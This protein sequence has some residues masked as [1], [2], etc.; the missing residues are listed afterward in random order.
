MTAALRHAWDARVRQG[1]APRYFDRQLGCEVI[2]VLP[3]EY[4]VSAADVT[5]LTLLGSCVAACIR[6]PLAGVGGM[7][8]FMLPDDERGTGGTNARYGAYAMEVLINELLKRGGQR[9]RLEA[10]V[11]GGGNVI[12]SMTGITVGNRN[13]EFV[14]DYLA[15]EGIVV[16][17]HDLG[18]E[19]A[20]KVAYHVKSGR[21]RVRHLPVAATV[22]DLTAEQAYGR[23]LRRASLAGEVEIFE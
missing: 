10:K 18:G 14:L 2:K 22:A 9:H 19:D 4:E 16:A 20:R 3:G 17:A 23:D 11:F 12:R 13:A 8:H 7:N 1:I 21:V 5:L 15:R 6:D